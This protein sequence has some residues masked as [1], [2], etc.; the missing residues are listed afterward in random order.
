MLAGRATSQQVKAANGALSA[1]LRRREDNDMI[2]QMGRVRIKDQA[3][4]EAKGRPGGRASAWGLRPDFAVPLP[5]AGRPRAPDGVTT[6][7]HFHASSITRLPS[8]G[9]AGTASATNHAIYVERPEAVEVASV[10]LHAGYVERPDAVEISD[11]PLISNISD[12]PARR[13]D[14]R[15]AVDRS[16]RQ[17]RVGYLEIN[18]GAP[19]GWW[20]GLAGDLPA[21]F[22][23]HCLSEEGRQR[24]HF[25]IPVDERKM[26]KPKRFKA[27]LEVCEAILAVARIV[28]G[29]SDEQSQ[30]KFKRVLAA[31]RSFD[32]SPNCRMS[33]SPKTVRRSSAS[34]VIISA[35]SR[36]IRT[37]RHRG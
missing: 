35:R 28:P 16:E 11:Q 1:L 22:Q 29:C 17:A 13:L 26:F 4:A 15:E 6:T 19:K 34:F 7:F 30:I 14:Y 32:T 2:L 5:C 21:D 9:P 31:A 10:P 27:D 36:V 12:D 18:V 3:A 33:S 25:A 8:A 23:A 20:R 37:A 24:A